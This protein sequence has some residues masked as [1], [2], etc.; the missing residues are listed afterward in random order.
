M[1]MYR[2]LYFA[3]IALQ[4]SVLIK[5]EREREREKK[6]TKNIA[7]FAYVIY[8]IYIYIDYLTTEIVSR[9]NVDDSVNSEYVGR[10]IYRIITIPW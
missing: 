3:I 6:Q 7:M 1:N 9:G 8:S 10:V 4:S 2:N 5:K